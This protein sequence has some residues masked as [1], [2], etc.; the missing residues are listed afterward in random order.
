MNEKIVLVIHGG[1]GAIVRENLSERKE[2]AYIAKL[3]ESLH[4]GHAILS[5]GGDA[6][7]AVIAASGK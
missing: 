3:T 2:L 6:V 7:S 4:A 5:S 1:A